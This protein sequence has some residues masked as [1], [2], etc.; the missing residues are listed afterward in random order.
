MESPGKDLFEEV[1]PS[2][3][4]SGSCNAGAQTAD[5]AKERDRTANER[6]LGMS[7]SKESF[8]CTFNVNGLACVVSDERDGRLTKSPEHEAVKSFSFGNLFNI[9]S[10]SS[11]RFLKAMRH[12]P[13]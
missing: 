10:R 9:L 11:G 7:Y 13:S 1:A 3:L 5:R 6:L 4:S 8:L 12:V 2:L